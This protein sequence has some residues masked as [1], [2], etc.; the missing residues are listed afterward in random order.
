MSD[1]LIYSK[2]IS[3]VFWFLKGNE[4]AKTIFF[5]SKHQGNFFFGDVFNSQTINIHTIYHQQFRKIYLLFFL[6]LDSKF[7]LFFFFFV[8]DESL[9]KDVVLE[10]RCSGVF[11]S[12]INIIIFEQITSHKKWSFCTLKCTKT[13]FFKFVSFWIFARSPYLIMCAII[14]H[15]PG[16]IQIS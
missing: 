6:F 10:G 7:T 5:F 3:V 9:A 2:K 4:T 12:K 8:L 15:S 13:R 16:K 11:F 14:L 1:S